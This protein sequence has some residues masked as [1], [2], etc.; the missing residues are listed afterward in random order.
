MNNILNY[1]TYG[2][3][4]LTFNEN[5]KIGGCVLNTFSQVTSEDEIISINLNKNNY[6][7]EVIKRTKKF[8]INIL[9]EE[10]DKNII[11]I[12]G[13]SSSKEKNKFENINYDLIDNLPVIKDGVIGYIT[14]E[15]I[16]IID[17]NTHDIV[18]A[19][20]INK[21]TINNKLI[22]MT[23]KYYHEVIKGNA[24]KNA[25]TYQEIEK[26]ISDKTIYICEICG[27]VHE[28]ELPDDF[29]CPICGAEKKYFRKNK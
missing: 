21:K 13:F 7:N 11:S 28:G 17:C 24:P 6:S 3:Y 19:K 22:P 29:I 14:C 16:N 9:G 15:I 18:I 20:I 8:N 12:F 27:Y 5:N 4:I 2:M 26:N 10:I 25:P 23:Y 1:I